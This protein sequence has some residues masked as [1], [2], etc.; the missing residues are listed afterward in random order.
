MEKVNEGFHKA[1]N[2]IY[3]MFERNRRAARQLPLVPRV[4]D[5]QVQTLIFSN[6]SD[7]GF[8]RQ[9]YESMFN[10][11]I[12]QATKFELGNLQGATAADWADFLRH[13]LPLCP[14]LVD[15]NLEYNEA[16]GGERAG[17]SHTRG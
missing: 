10:D 16:I 14:D 6:G 2:S 7:R 12:T 9:K 4:F 1:N 3:F 5:E 11:V 17:K 8:V 15:V 13:V